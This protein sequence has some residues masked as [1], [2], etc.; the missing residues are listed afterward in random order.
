MSMSSPATNP[1]TVDP[2]TLIAWTALSDSDQTHLLE[3]LA[4]L[5]AQPLEQWPA[6]LVQHLAT[7]EPLYLLYGPND[8]LVVFRK[9][10]DGITLLDLV[11]RETIERYF[12]SKS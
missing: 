10:A 11:L 5:A 1:V 6:N 12:V 9:T 7:N 8:V 4:E 3:T 2:R